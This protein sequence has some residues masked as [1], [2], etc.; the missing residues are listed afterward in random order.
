MFGTGKKV[1]EGRNL[2]PKDPNGLS[3]PF[4]TFGPI[5]K[6][7]NWSFLEKKSKPFKSKVT[8]KTLN[9]VWRMPFEMYARPFF[10][11]SLFFFFYFFLGPIGASNR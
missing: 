8:R 5:D 2:A 7:G 4:L 10:S 11:F 1:L 6:K 3:D 9:P